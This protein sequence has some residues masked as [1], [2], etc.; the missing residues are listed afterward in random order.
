VLHSRALEPARSFVFDVADL[1][2]G[3][4][5]SLGLKAG[6]TDAVSDHRPVVVDFALRPEAR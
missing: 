4:A 3:S 6:D 1:T 2:A 5:Q